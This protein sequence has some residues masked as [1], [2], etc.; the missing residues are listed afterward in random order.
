MSYIMV[1]IESDGPIPGPYSMVSFG[2]VVVKEGLK[3][4]FYGELKPISDKWDPVALSISGISREKHLTFEDP[5]VVMARFAAWIKQVSVDRPQF[6]ADNNGFDWQFINWYFHSFH[7]SNPFGFSSRNLGD[8]WKGMKGDMFTSFKH[9]RMTKHT[10]HP[11]DDAKG[12][13]EALLAMKDMG[14]TI[15]LV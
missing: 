12:N 13:A 5:T 6:I 15:K 2:A 3:D 11:V 1:D 4:T 14:L 8:I 10:H 7:G 9:L